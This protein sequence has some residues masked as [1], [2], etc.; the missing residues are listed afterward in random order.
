MPALFKK[1]TR[2]IKGFSKADWLA[3]ALV[4]VAAALRFYNLENSQQFLGDQ[5]RDSL[6]VSRI[7]TERDPVLIGPV[8]SIG[9][10][11]LG[12]F[13]YYF[14]LPTLWL[15]YPSPMGPIYAMALVGSFT[16]GLIY[17]LG[18]RMLGTRAAL[19]ATAF[20]TLS[21]LA[22]TFTRFSWNPNPAP[23]FSLLLVFFTY[24]AWKDNH[25]YWIA[26]AA[27]MSILMQLHYVTLLAFGGFGV[28]WLLNLREIISKK[29]Q[30]AAFVK[31]TLLA[32]GVLLLSLTP[33]LLFDIRHDWLNLNAFKN[34]FVKEDAFQASSSPGLLNRMTDLLLSFRSRAS[35]LFV[36][37]GFR[38]D[39]AWRFWLIV[40][41]G[42]FAIFIWV[43]NKAI[44]N[45]TKD[46]K[47]F[48]TLVSYILFSIIGLSLYAQPIYEHYVLFI[49]PV[50][51]LLYGWLLDKLALRFAKT[52][53]IVAAVS[54]SAFI[55]YN[56]QFM[57]L[58]DAGW[59]IS[60]I[61]RTATEIN[62]RVIPGEKYNIVLLAE[63][64]DLYGQNY[65]YFLSTYH[66]SKP[67]DPEREVEVETLFII[68][69]ERKVEDVTELPIY[70]IQIFPN[71]EPVEVFSIPDGP[72]ITLLRSS[73]QT[74]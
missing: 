7:F 24:K 12:P 25:R 13:Y 43:D 69:E 8:T 2:K 68:N 66:G 20:L 56:F 64:R 21:S 16:V 5:G 55:F 31:S 74:E 39:I 11:Y 59:K 73:S 57:P 54:M 35:L 48:I 46:K 26:A 47:A 15:S 62:K 22:I 65:R 37:V 33:Q 58:Q 9:N 38:V 18:K 45:S 17:L 36:K 6:V 52:G 40:A 42:L 34:M 71:K 28:I 30:L 14:M 49:L 70:Q 60:D 41:S 44:K 27:S 32:A 19:F 72:E 10:M 4:I 29:N 1:V 51:F 50:T 63:S 67:V 61:E 53:A 3:L 23:L